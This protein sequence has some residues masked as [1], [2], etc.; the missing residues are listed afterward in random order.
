MKN[1]AELNRIIKNSMDVGYKIPDAAKSEVYTSV[2]RPFDVMGVHEGK[3]VFI[4]SK[5]MKEL[6]AFSFSLIRD[7][8]IQWLNKFNTAESSVCLVALGVKVTSRDKR[9]YLFD[10]NYINDL[11]SKG[12]K[13]IKAKDLKTLAFQQITKDFKLKI[14]NFIIE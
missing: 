8:Q 6:K 2:A 10:I 9:L 3:C 14:A 1:E 11:I 4:E 7:H 5:F 12:E 13:S